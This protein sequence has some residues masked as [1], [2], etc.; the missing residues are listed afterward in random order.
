[1][2]I[3]YNSDKTEM[4]PHFPFSNIPGSGVPV[5]IT[6][7][8]DGNF[9]IADTSCVAKLTTH[10]DYVIIDSTEEGTAGTIYYREPYNAVTVA[11]YIEVK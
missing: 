6:V 11:G 2:D 8:N 5:D 3:K 4:F 9:L 10:Y 1:M 7:D